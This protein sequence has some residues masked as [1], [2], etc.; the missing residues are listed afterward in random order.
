M[1]I[2]DSG[3]Y[4]KEKFRK[5]EVIATFHGER[6]EGRYALFQTDGKNWMIHRMD[7]PLDPT[8]SGMPE[9]IEPMLAKLGPLPK[10]DSD[11]GYEVKWDGVRAICFSDHGHVRL[12]NRNLRDCSTQYPEVK[13]IGRA[14]RSNRVV[15]DGEV[16]ALDEAGRPD[17]GL[18]QRRM[19]LGSASAV[20]Q[21]VKDTPVTYMIFDLLYLN[22]H[23]TM[24]LPYEQRRSLL[25]QLELEGP[26]WRTP[27]YRAGDGAVM[28]D[29]SA[30]QGLEGIVAKRLDS[31]YRPGARGG[32][33]IKVKNHL[34]QEF[35]VGGWLPGKG[36]RSKSIGSLALGYYENREL[37]YAGNVGT[38]F[39]DELLVELK[40]DLEKL[41]TGESPFSGRQPPKQTVFVAPEL[42]AQV[43]FGEWTR[44][45]TI[46]HPTF[47]GM[48][49]DKNPQDVV[50]ETADA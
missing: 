41:R 25:E 9:K 20:R 13:R 30:E 35:V 7:P 8:A 43:E 31:D 34:E 36:R 48:R 16:V 22:G 14:L 17:F 12:Q 38:G 21:R 24:P 23:S 50:L 26:H 18:L 6:L 27:A 3:S 40:S 1:T 45:R 15:L 4:E 2:W 28:L 29:A 39:S 42:V 37:I 44:D 10:A 32:A 19:H 49:D 46:R 47:K 33:W 11:Y 5:D